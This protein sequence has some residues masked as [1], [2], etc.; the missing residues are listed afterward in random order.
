LLG[1][2]HQYS[3]EGDGISDIGI[4]IFVVICRHIAFSLM[5]LGIVTQSRG[6]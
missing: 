4:C 6:T 2:I 3:R 1:H 5:V